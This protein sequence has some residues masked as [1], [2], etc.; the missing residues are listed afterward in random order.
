MLGLGG[1]MEGHADL[2]A[3]PLDLG[4]DVFM[5]HEFAAEVLEVGPD[6]VGPPSGH[7]RHV[8]PDPA[9]DDR[10]S[11]HRLQQRPAGRLRRA[12]AAVGAD[13]A[14]GAQRAGSAPR[15]PHRADGGRPARRQPLRDRRRRRRARAR[16]RPGR[17]R[18]DRAPSRS[19]A[20]SPSWPPTS[21][22]PAGRSP[23]P[24]ARTR[25]STLWS[26]RRSTPGSGPDGGQAPRRVRG[27]RRARHHRRRPA[28]G[29]GAA[30][31]SWS[32]AC[33]WSPTRSRPSSGSARS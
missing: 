24:W 32:W 30:A 5:G 26:S 18:R 25:S 15:R 20:S 19:G 21:P 23:R 14:R 9:D 4:R 13:A 8:G 28:G 17:P 6:T 3:P 22:R 16:L 31:A 29:A 7:D 33:A 27:H 10:R 12:H 11:S 1:R 2:G